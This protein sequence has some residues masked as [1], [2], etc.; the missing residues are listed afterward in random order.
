MD[1]YETE[2][3]NPEIVSDEEIK[4]NIVFLT[5]VLKTEVCLFPYCILFSTKNGSIFVP[6]NTVTGQ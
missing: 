4:E 3:G 1:N 6:I 2:V 5:A